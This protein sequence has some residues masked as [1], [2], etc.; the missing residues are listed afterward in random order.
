[1]KKS[2]FNQLFKPVIFTLG[3]LLFSINLEAQ[4]PIGNVTINSQSELIQF[5]NNYPNCTIIN[6]NL[7]ISSLVTDLTPLQNIEEIKGDLTISNTN[8]EDLT[9][10]LSI[11]KINGDLNIINNNL[12][13]HVNSFN[14]LTEVSNINIDRISGYFDGF[15][16]LEKVN[17]IDLNNLGMSLDAFQNL[18]FVEESLIMDDL[19]LALRIYQ[20]FN[21]VEYIKGSLVI[22]D[23]PHGIGLFS[24]LKYIGNDL[25][26][27][28]TGINEIEGFNKLESIGSLGGGDFEITESLELTVFTGF[29]NLQRVYGNMVITGNPE[30]P[31]ISGFYNLEKIDRALIIQNNNRL[32]ALTGLENL[33]AVSN[34][35]GNLG[36]IV[37]NNQELT[38][39][40][41]ICNLLANNRVYDD[42]EILNNPSE[43]STR[44]E[45]ES[46]C[47]PD[48]DND[49]IPDDIDLDDDNDGIPDIIED[50]G[51]LDRDSDNDGSPDKRDLDSD[52]DGCYD[53]LEAGFNDDDDNGTL[54]NSP[55]TVDEDGLI[56]NET[57]GY[58]TPLDEDNNGIY[59][60]QEAFTLSAGND[61][62]INLCQE[63]NAIDLFNYLGKDAQRG[64]TW[65]PNL[66]SNSSVFDPSLDS[67][68]IYAY[69][70]NNYCIS[71]TAIIEIN[72]EPQPEPGLDTNISICQ[73]EEAFRL[74]DYL[75]GNPD[76]N[77]Y[78]EP[79]LPNGIFDP[80]TNEEGTYT[81][82]IS[83]E[84]CEVLTSEIIISFLDRTETISYEYSTAL[85]NDGSYNIFFETANESG[86]TFSLDDMTDQ[87]NGYFYNISPGI[88]QIKITEING[89]GIV[90]EQIALIGFPKYFSPNSDG[91]ND[92]WQPLGIIDNEVQT[93][94]Y[95]RYGTLLRKLQGDEHWDGSYN[96]KPM[97][98]DDYWFKALIG[99]ESE[100]KGHFSLIR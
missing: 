55:D 38:D 98:E 24:E 9:T 29:N 73:Y 2:N 60:F 68:G 51:I 8:I 53:V 71:Q 47:L 31:E 42:V 96:G 75:E 81:Y 17:T 57:T 35:F 28:R 4:C 100:Q 88:H 44:Q 7:S 33:N 92:F 30:L 48:F 65:S 94:I 61:A 50:N 43:C 27:N 56:I 76:S 32:A 40:S 12:L 3:I 80:Q 58:T 11:S 86:Y 45:I 34:N 36:L 54:G 23:Y 84:N 99:Q 74:V 90:N 49:G 1:M 18:K 5:Q 59:D 14:E 13:R 78:W 89:C 37:S 95:D 72:F 16:K 97:P 6:A 20:A 39:C 77:G 69:T 10:E 91:M 52:N 79:S 82:H 26:I 70:V 83:N 15:N 63:G 19:G 22:R 25:F 46:N 21:K 67:E 85:N 62:S 87:S 93:Y 66:A 41:A 64:G